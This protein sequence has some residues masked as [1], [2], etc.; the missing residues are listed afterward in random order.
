MNRIASITPVLAFLL[1]LEGGSVS[2]HA[3][4]AADAQI[5][6]QQT[7]RETD[8]TWQQSKSLFDQDE[9]EDLG[10]IT[11]LKKPKSWFIT[12]R[13]AVRGFW[14]S[15]ALLASRGEK[16]DSVFV[17]SQGVDAGY[18][19]NPDWDLAAGYE[20]SLT[21]YDE[22]PVLDTDA[23]ACSFNTTYRLPWNIS[24]SGGVR[25]LWLNAPHQGAEVYRE[26][27]PYFG[28]NRWHGFCDDRL[29]WYYGLQY[30]HHFANPVVFDRD[31]FSV[32]TGVAWSWLPNLI[33]QLALRQSWQ[34]YDF[35]GPPLLV[36]G[37]QEAVST[38]ALQTVWQ[39][40][41]HLQVSAFGVTSYDN[42]VNST[43]DYKVA[44]V[45]GELKFFWKF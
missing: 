13:V 21:R 25:G 10:H 36:N 45:G 5:K 15:N 2:V 43:R 16:G 28:V 3:Q 22:N 44:N 6:S 34:F 35:R 23:H 31:E 14:T 7:Q 24:L 18:R 32:N 20:Y 38:V 11:L 19:I 40:I 37:R 41:D 33:S 12:P 17:E 26:N 9:Q 39:P 29:V 1:L 4:A 30:D 27:N 8:A 42:S